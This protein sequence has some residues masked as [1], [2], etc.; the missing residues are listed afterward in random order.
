MAAFY[1]GTSSF[2]GVQLNVMGKNGKVPSL[3]LFSDPYN[4]SATTLNPLTVEVRAWKL[5]PLFILMPW[6]HKP[7]I[8]WQQISIINLTFASFFVICLPVQIKQ[9]ARKEINICFSLFPIT[10]RLPDFKTFRVS[11]K[12]KSTRLQETSI[13]LIICASC[14]CF[15]IWFCRACC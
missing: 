2:P 1:L 11:N 15:P 5:Y 9:Q 6:W 7:D 12:S 3:F 4:W 14:V 8:S 10:G 13:F